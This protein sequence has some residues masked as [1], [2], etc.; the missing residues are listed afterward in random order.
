MIDPISDKSQS[1][2][3]PSSSST[4]NVDMDLDLTDEGRV[5]YIKDMMKLSSPAYDKKLA[6]LLFWPKVTP[7]SLIFVR[8]QLII[9]YL[10]SR[11][12]GSAEKDA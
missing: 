5:E 7:I 2:S 4:I 11:S 12:L 8:L 10:C 1:T 9:R 3:E 6:Q